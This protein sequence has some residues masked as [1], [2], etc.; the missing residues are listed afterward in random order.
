MLRE[1]KPL[2]AQ[3]GHSD[4]SEIAG[5]FESGE[6]KKAYKYCRQMGFELDDFSDSLNVMGRK[7]FHS[8]PGE[9][10]ALIYKYR[11]DAGYDIVGLLKSQLSLN[12]HHGF[13]KNV[14]RFGLF[15]DFAPEVEV[16]ISSLK[17]EKEAQAWRDKLYT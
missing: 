2:R 5:L 15:T 17:R 10:L 8:R 7:M 6:F 1:F 9:L 16:A 3:R 4:R 13:L 14:H 12:D 11:I